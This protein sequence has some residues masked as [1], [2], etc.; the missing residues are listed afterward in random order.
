MALALAACQGSE[1]GTK[2]LTTTTPPASGQTAGVQG[3][4][5]PEICRSTM[6]TL[7]TRD[8]EIWDKLIG[9]PAYRHD[10]KAHSDFMHAQ[11]SAYLKAGCKE[12]PGADLGSCLADGTESGQANTVEANHALHD[13]CFAAFLANY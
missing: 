8:Q 4:R 10:S 5:I 11:I 2:M 3:I 7:S 13:R 9:D 1:N 6:Q 12:K